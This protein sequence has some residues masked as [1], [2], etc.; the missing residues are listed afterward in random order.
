ME[1]KEKAE[2]V[3]ELT[4]NLKGQIEDMLKPLTEQVAS[5]ANAA[6]EAAKTAAE[7]VV[8]P[9]TEKVEALAGVVNAERD[10]E[11]RDLVA[12]LSTNNRTPF[13]EAELEAKPLEEL[14]KIA[15]IAAV[16]VAA[17]YM[18]RGAPRVVATNTDGEDVVQF[19]EPVP[20]FAQNNK[21]AKAAGQEA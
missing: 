16:P 4:T 14:R 10:A 13:T 20:Y 12:K 7:A 3:D 8:A 17:N 6:S 19:A 1:A 5:V 2:I 18:G 9:L 11:R 21:A 15:Q